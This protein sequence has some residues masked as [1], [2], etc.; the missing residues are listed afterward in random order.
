MRDYSYKIAQISSAMS[1]YHSA[2]ISGTLKDK[3]ETTYNTMISKME[4]A[5]MNDLIAAI[6]KQADEFIK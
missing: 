3:Y 2:L 5:G 4:A 1:E 6:Q